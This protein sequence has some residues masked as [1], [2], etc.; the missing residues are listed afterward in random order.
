M[1]LEADDAVAEVDRLLEVVGDE[2]DCRPGRARD[3][4]HLV[5]EA[6]A[7]HRVKRAERLVH[8]QRRGLLRETARDLEPLLHAAGH[9]RGIFLRVGEEADPLQQFSDARLALAAWRRHRL[10]RQRDIAGG[11]APR[12]QRL[13]IVLEHDRDVPARPLDRRAGESDLAARRRDEPGGDAQRR[14][15]AAAGRADDADDL[16]APDLE[17]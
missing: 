13:G 9:L 8:H 2:E 12:Q 16:A 7:G 10:E 4:E 5:L 14:R 11:G 1:R 17:R 3:F 6:L 15:L